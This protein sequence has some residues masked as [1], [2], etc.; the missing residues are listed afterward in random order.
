MN[1]VNADHAVV[2]PAKVRD[3]LLSTVHPVGRF[4]AAL[5]VGLGYSADQWEVLRDDILTLA[6]TAQ[7]LRAQV[8]TRWYPDWTIRAFGCG[9]DRV[10]FPSGGAVPAF[11]HRYAEVSHVQPS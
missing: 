2:D 11:R 7:S 9:Q 3:Y 5:F 4:K 6:R 8:R 1:L 10:D